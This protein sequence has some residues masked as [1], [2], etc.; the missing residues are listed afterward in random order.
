MA[1]FCDQTVP[2]AVTTLVLLALFSLGACG[3]ADM[4]STNEDG[5][6]TT[7]AASSDLAELDA[8]DAD[9]VDLAD[10]GGDTTCSDAAPTCHPI[11]YGG[12][13]MPDTVTATCAQGQWT[14]PADSAPFDECTNERDFCPM[15]W[16]D[17]G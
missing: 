17:A 11:P 16:V 13:C 15:D 3:G 8:G 4:Q 6:V 9:T 2:V 10:A 12:C 14:C 5:S 1:R 7:D